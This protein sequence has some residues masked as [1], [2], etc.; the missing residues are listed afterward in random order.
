[1]M[2]IIAIVAVMAAYV[3]RRVLVKGREMRLPTEVAMMAAP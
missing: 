2:A 1:M 3:M